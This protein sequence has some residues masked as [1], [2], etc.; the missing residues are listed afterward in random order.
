M[1]D[2]LRR[3]AAALCVHDRL[4]DHPRVQTADWYYQRF[5][6]VSYGGSYDERQLRAEAKHLRGLVRDG[7]DV[8]AY[9]NNDIGGHA[10]PNALALRR[11]AQA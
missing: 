5:H 1:Y 3:H 4:P 10:I 11:L 9:F 8:Y 2:V 6:G 7:I